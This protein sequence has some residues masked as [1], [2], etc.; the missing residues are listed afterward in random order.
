M[1]EASM[2]ERATTLDDLVREFGL[3]V[4]A[5]RMLLKRSVEGG[6]V[7]D[8][9]SDVIAHAKRGDVWLTLQG[10]PNVIAAAVLK[11]LAGIIMING[12]TPEAETVKK[13]EEQGIPILSSTLPAF[14]LAGR[15]YA[16]GISGR[17]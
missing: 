3:G 17:H 14:E 5:G 7:S 16:F 1:E 8:L 2:P 13:A 6:Y 15:L 12:R 4:E 10:H 9:L 11:E